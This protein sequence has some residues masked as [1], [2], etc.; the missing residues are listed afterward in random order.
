[1]ILGGGPAFCKGKRI[2]LDRMVKV[3]GDDF[4][5]LALLEA[6]QTSLSG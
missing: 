4:A 2:I 3:E 1:M 5:L 6:A